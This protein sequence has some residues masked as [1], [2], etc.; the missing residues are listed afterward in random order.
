MLISQNVLMELYQVIIFIEI[1]NPSIGSFFIE[2]GAWCFNH[3]KW[4]Q[5][6]LIQSVIVLNNCYIWMIQCYLI[7]S[8]FIFVIEVEQYG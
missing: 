8:Q 3:K 5:I 2:G 7:I 6:Y 4:Y 1:I